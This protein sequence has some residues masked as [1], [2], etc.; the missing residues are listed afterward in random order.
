LRAVCFE[1]GVSDSDYLNPIEEP[2]LEVVN[3]KIKKKKLTKSDF[4]D[5][6]V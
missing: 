1:L 3:L 6:K 5:F 2:Q 4:K